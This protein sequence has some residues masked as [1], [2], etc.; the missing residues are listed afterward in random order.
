MW[1]L[2]I[3]DVLVCTRPILLSHISSFQCAMLRLVCVWP[4]ISSFYCKVSKDIP[5]CCSVCVFALL[6]VCVSYVYVWINEWSLNK[7]YI[8]SECLRLM[9][10]S[11]ALATCQWQWHAPMLCWSHI[12]S[13]ELGNVWLLAF[14]VWFLTFVFFSLVQNENPAAGTSKYWTYHIKVN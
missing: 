7:V 11:A 8:V 10:I 6:W 3:L 12:V 13:C 4:H 5:K 2:F 14:T 9:S 1:L